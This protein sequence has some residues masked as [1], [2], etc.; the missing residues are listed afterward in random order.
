MYCDKSCREQ[1]RKYFEAQR[2]KTLLQYEN[3]PSEQ[4]E[5]PDVFYRNTHGFLERYVCGFQA[6]RILCDVEESR[7]DQ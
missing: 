7:L 3:H 6:K 4:W 5:E 1:R 2:L